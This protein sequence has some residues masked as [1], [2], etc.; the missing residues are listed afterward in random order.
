MFVLDVIR[1]VCVAR[2]LG[3]VFGSLVYAWCSAGYFMI[4]KGLL[5]QQSVE[6]I[7]HASQGENQHEI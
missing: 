2:W 7:S 6:N 4:Y 3:L 5:V 1:Q